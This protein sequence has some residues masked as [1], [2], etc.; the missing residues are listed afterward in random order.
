MS[1]ACGMVDAMA[2]AKTDLWSGFD[3]K[4]LTKVVG[5]PDYV[6]ENTK[7]RLRF[8]GGVEDYKETV[9]R[10]LLSSESL[11][12]EDELREFGDA[13]VLIERVASSVLG[14]DPT[15]G[16]VGSDVSIPDAPDLPTKPGAPDTTGMDPRI[17][18][19]EDRNYESKV[20]RWIADSEAILDLFDQASEGATLLGARQTWLDSWAARDRLI[21][22]LQENELENIVGLGDGVIEVSWDEE[23]GR[24]VTAIHDPKSYIPV[25]DKSKASEFPDVVHLVQ[26]YDLQVGEKVETRVRRVTY[27]LVPVDQVEAFKPVAYLPEGKTQTHTCL[28]SDRTWLLK[29]FGDVYSPKGTPI[30]T[31]TVTVEGNPVDLVRY[32]TGYDFVPVLHVPNILSTKYH[33]GRSLISRLMQLLDEIASLDSDEALSSN[34]TARPPMAIKGLPSGDKSVNLTAGQGIS[35][36]GISVPDMAGNLLALMDRQGNLQKRL[37]TNSG[38]TDAL[39]G[40]VDASKVPSGIA[41][42]LSFTP[43]IQLIKRLRESRSAK[44]PLLLKMV[45]RIAIQNIDRSGIDSAEVHDAEIRFGAFMPQDLPTAVELLAR[46]YNAQMISLETALGELK[47][48]GLSIDDLKAEFAS[49]RARDG[50]TA[51]SIADA[52]GSSQAGI[53]YMGLDMEAP[54]GVD[55]DGAVVPPADADLA[56]V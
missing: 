21:G 47:A 56:T 16:I 12:G 37:S 3:H 17:A 13:A 54:G 38:V 5:I 11:H 22:R 28:H 6:D 33:F 27:E 35:G 49:I 8:Y 43:F 41:F 1:T 36:D 9:A 15:V 19:I 42:V 26:Q 32:N 31:G 18:A 7:R 24:P 46:L 29:D 14:A 34:W 25:L 52:T 30:A 51:L 55:P 48:A 44:Y 50:H 4:A 40:R 45:Q 2:E 39:R 23:A 10:R 53:D 20:V